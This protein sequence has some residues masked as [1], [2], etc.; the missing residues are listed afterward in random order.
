MS[1]R[2]STK[3]TVLV[4]LWKRCIFSHILFIACINHDCNAWP[5][6]KRQ[7]R[8]MGLVLSSWMIH[9]GSRTFS[10]DWDHMHCVIRCCLAWKVMCS[11]GGSGCG[12]SLP[13]RA[14]PLDGT[15]HVA[16][17]FGNRFLCVDLILSFGGVI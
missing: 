13:R 16:Q 10:C 11:L 3:E 4:P 15:I 17:K 1:P 12:P 2:S 5:S 6:I 7:I 14:F 9:R 8:S